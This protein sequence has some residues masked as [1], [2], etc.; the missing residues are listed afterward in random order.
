M[1]R[2]EKEENLELQPT[3]PRSTTNL[4]KNDLFTLLL[5]PRHVRRVAN[6]PILAAHGETGKKISSDNLSNKHAF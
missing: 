1:H 4:T 2:A 6:R 3:L 5:I